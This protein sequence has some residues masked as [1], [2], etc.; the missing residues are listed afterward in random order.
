MLATAINEPL[1][2][3]H[4]FLKEEYTDQTGRLTPY[5]G[6]GTADLIGTGT[7]LHGTA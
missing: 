2:S 5:T 3:V 1:I 6:L 4:D 7:Y